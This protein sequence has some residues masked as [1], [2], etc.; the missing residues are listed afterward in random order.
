MARCLVLFLRKVSRKRYIVFSTINLLVI[1]VTVLILTRQR[2][3]DQMMAILIGGKVGHQTVSPQSFVTEY[4]PGPR[5]NHD[6]VGFVRARSQPNGS[7][8]L[9]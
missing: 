8:G 6:R 1:S 3:K 9:A 4:V 5:L 2:I 7:E